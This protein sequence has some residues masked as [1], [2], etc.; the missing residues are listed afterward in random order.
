[1]AVEPILGACHCPDSPNEP[2]PA[3]DERQHTLPT[4]HADRDRT[5]TK[6]N[7]RAQQLGRMNGTNTTPP[8]NQVD[9]RYRLKRM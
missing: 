1:M 5:G 7:Q 6:I 3:V 4:R 2:A 8:P 9:L